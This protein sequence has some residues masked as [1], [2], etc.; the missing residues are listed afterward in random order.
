M[1]DPIYI[2]DGQAVVLSQREQVAIAVAM[3]ALDLD[4]E[5]A[6]RLAVDMRDDADVNGGQR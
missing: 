6:V 3:R 5:S 4:L 2:V 1:I